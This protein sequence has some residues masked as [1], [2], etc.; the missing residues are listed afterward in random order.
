MAKWIKLPSEPFY[1]NQNQL[2]FLQARAERVCKACKKIYQAEPPLG[3][4]PTCG[5]KG[6]RRWDR[7]TIIAGRRWGKSMIGSIAGTQEAG[8][9]ETIGWACAPTN[10]KLNRYVIPAFQ[11]LIPPEHVKDYNSEFKD[12]WLKNGSLIHFQTLED[13]DQGRGQGL[14]W[15]W[16]DEVCELSKKHWEVIRPSLA[17]DTIAFFTTSPRSYDWVYEELYKPAEDNVPGYW[18]CHAKT[19]ESANPRITA[20]F[21]A[22]EKAQMSEAMYR[23]EYEADFVIFT[24]AVYGGLVDSQILHT[25]E[26]VRKIIPEWPDVAPWRQVLVGIDTGADHPFGAVKLISSEKGLVVVGEYLERHK[27]FIQHAN[28]LKRLAWSNNVRWGINRNERQPIIELSQHGIFPQPAEN[29]IVAGTERVKSW[30]YK[31]QLWFVAD[32]CPL[33]IKQMKAY[34]WADN[35]TNDDQ[36]REREKVY[37][38]DDELPDCVRYAL[39]TWPDIPTDPLPEVKP[40]D[41]SGFSPEMQASIERIR[42]I[43]NT[44]PAK[45]DSVVG[46]FWL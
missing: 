43:E 32:A 24:G 21:L 31:K 14:D 6:F 27:T 15:L 22:R 18:A 3:V 34:R 25:A 13:P 16:I 28:A 36:K 41:L 4:C 11:R 42:K 29:D 2:E 10:P 45:E 39:M 19:S 37:K 23:Q 33:T 35:L 9:E 46:D 20:D 1:R 12:L 30:L 26:D 7:L 17:G 38:K 5:K 44:P 40:R 8:M